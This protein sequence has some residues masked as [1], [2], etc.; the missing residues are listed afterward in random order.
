MWYARGIFYSNKEYFYS[1]ATLGNLIPERQISPAEF[2]EASIEFEA[3]TKSRNSHR[4][5]DHAAVIAIL[6]IFAKGYAR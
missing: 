4:R 6:Q 2:G 3:S 5:A 1:N